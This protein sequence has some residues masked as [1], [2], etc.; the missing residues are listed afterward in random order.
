[1][2]VLWNIFIVILAVWLEIVWLIFLFGSV[3][4]VVL[5]LIFMPSGF[6]FPL[7]LLGFMAGPKPS[8]TTSAI[9]ARPEN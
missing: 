6:G 5:L 7:L 1:M 3:L 2:R 8:A 4:G 9:P